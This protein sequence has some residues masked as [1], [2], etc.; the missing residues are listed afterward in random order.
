M[1]LSGQI[2]MYLPRNTCLYCAVWLQHVHKA[3]I[4]SPVHLIKDMHILHPLHS[5]PLSPSQHVWA[6]FFFL[7]CPHVGVWPFL[8]SPSFFLSHSDVCHPAFL[9]STICSSYS[10]C[11]A[12]WSCRNVAWAATCWT[13]LLLQTD[14]RKTGSDSH[15]SW[16]CVA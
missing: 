6:S 15:L 2:W 3:A 8:L 12:M 14:W 11:A 13:L 5:H 16:F 7:S 10:I 4:I 1:V 9:V